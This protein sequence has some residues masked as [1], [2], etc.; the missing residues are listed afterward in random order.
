LHPSCFASVLGVRQGEI[1]Y[2]DKLEY[3][4]GHL[5]I[6]FEGENLIKLP[7]IALENAPKSGFFSRMLDKI[8]F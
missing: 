2:L 5:I 1:T 6:K 8:R 3:N 4:I 7:I